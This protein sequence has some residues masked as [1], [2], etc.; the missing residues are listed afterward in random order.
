MS[1]GGYESYY[2]RSQRREYASHYVDYGTIKSLL[3]RYYARRRLFLRAMN[4]CGGRR[5]RRDG[6]I[7]VTRYPDL[8]DVVIVEAAAA[9]ASGGGYDL[10]GDDEDDVGGGG[11]YHLHREDD[12]YGDD[13]DDGIVVDPSSHPPSPRAVPAY[14]DARVASRRLARAERREF[15]D[16]VN[17]ELRR[18]ARFYVDTLLPNVRRHLPSS[19]SSSS[20]SSHDDGDGDDVD[21]GRTSYADAGSS[22]LEA[23]AF[24]ITNAITYRQILIRYEAFNW[25]FEV[26]DEGRSSSS[27]MRRSTRYDGGG[28]SAMDDDDHDDDASYR[29]VRRMLNLDGIEEM[30]KLI[31]V[32]A[33]ERAN[34]RKLSLSSSSYDRALSGRGGVVVDDDDDDDD[35]SLP[36]EMTAT[37]VEDLTAQVQSFRCLLDRTVSRDAAVRRD[38]ESGMRTVV[39]RDRMLALCSRIVD[40]LLIDLQRRGLISMR[41]RHLKNEIEIIARWR[42]SKDLTHF[43]YS[44]DRGGAI[45]RGLGE[46][47]EEN[48]FPLVLNLVSCFLFMMNSYIIEPSSAHYAEALG[49]ED[50]VAGLM[51]GATPLFALTSCV[52]YSF[53]TNYN[54]RNPLLFAGC[55]QFIGN[56]MYANAY[57]YRSVELCLLGRAMT[58]LGAPRIINRRY[59]ADA[60]PF[61]LRTMTSA[62]FAMAMAVGSAMGPGMAIVLDGLPE[63]QFDL[64]FLRTQ[65]FNGMTGPGYFMSLNW[66]VY[67]MCIAFFFTEPT[68][69][70]LEE[71]KRREEG[72][73]YDE[74]ELAK[75]SSG[76]SKVPRRIASVSETS[77]D[78]GLQRQFSLLS[79]EDNPDKSKTGGGGGVFDCCSCVT[80]ITRPV[81]ICMSLIYM[82][83][84]TLESIVGSTSIITKN[85]YG[86]TIKNVGSLHLAN[87]II[88]IPVSIFSGYLSTLYEDRYMMIWFMSITLLGMAFLMDPTD[89]MNH[90]DN[91][92]YNAGQPWAVGP[93]RYIAGSLIAFSGVEACESYIASLISKVVPSALAQGTFNSGLLA[94][95]VGTVRHVH[96]VMV[97]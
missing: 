12:Y 34:E 81:V 68:R 27:R 63:F 4:E 40:Y 61:K 28:R 67:T 85:R 15:D 51:L 54:Y 10:G 82:K 72:K 69:S 80:N 23:V 83:R 44:L 47:R 75:I 58:G 2:H 64:P 65:Y 20:S 3:N 92:T 90:D 42:Q 29:D 43:S 11:C 57:A 56:F 55:L 38:A 50:A 70:G 96:A 19:S 25:T 49:S 17:A 14:V 89:L 5:R 77:L 30:E 22:L 88:V 18:A 94:T 13:D 45:K 95:L 79:N 35:A 48:V 8:A 71:L 16:L 62:A 78:D 37:D 24:A 41:G 39:M 59:V 21:I 76:D 52:A 73:T 84:I 53:W 60:T 31:V 91:Y 46:I 74:V 6:R 32:G 87:G 93:S 9:A 86:W 1:R 66:F 7:D 36:V 26:V 97:A 33:M